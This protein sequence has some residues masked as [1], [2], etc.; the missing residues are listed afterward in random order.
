VDFYKIRTREEKSKVVIYPDFIVGRSK[1]LMVRGKAFY[2]IWDEKRQL[3]STDEYD[4]QRLVDEELAQFVSTLDVGAPY[5]VKYLRSSSS[6]SWYNFRKFVSLLSDNS[7]ELDSNL[8]FAN[9]EVKKGDYVSRKLPYSIASGDYSAWDEM[10]GTLYSVE[11]RAKIEWAVGAIISGDSKN[12]QKFLVLYG[13]AGTGKSTVLNILQKLF[14]GYT[15]SFEAK[16]LGSS[17]AA[18]A[19]EVFRGN[20]LVAI[21]HDG[22]L[23]RIDDNTKLNSII[24]HEEMTMHEKYKPSYTSRVN[25]FLFMGTNQPVKISDAK[26]GIIRRLI[27]VHPTGVR[28]PPNHY[29]TLNTK[30]DFELGAIAQHCLDVYREMGKNYYNAYRPLE[31]MLQTDVFFNF[32]EYAFDVFKE[33]N[34]TTLAGLCLV[35][36]VLL[37][38]WN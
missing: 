23:S 29:T 30:I 8:T 2:A 5:S 21:Q 15:T 3:W 10:L 32:V 18:F 26:S 13:P 25:A 12:I 24:A 17:S 36:G 28:I 33:Q 16:A 35:Q 14:V 27:D 20:P 1:D 34:S 37:V 4:V 7:H 19:T 6:G 11:E 31:M 22:D 38:N 9:S